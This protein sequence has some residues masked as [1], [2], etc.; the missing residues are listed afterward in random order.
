MPSLAVCA[1]F[2]DEA[3]FVE[4]WVAYHALIG[5]DHFFLYDNG[6]TDG[7]PEL[8]SNGPFRRQITLT[9]IPD[10]PGQFKAYRHFVDNFAKS[11][12]WAAFI[13]LDEFIQT[14]ETDD[15]HDLLPRY[16]G[17]SGVLLQ[18]LMFGPSGQEQRPDGL[19]IDSY[20]QRMPDDYLRN[21]HVKSLVRVA[22]ID[23]SRII[24]SAHLIPV[25]GTVCNSR[26]EEVAK[27]PIQPIACHDVVV[28]NHYYTKSR[29]DWETK[30][31]KGRADTHDEQLRRL[32]TWF[33]NYARDAVIYDTR[34]TRFSPAV[35]A[36]MA[37]E[38]AQR[39]LSQ[40]NEQHMES[41]FPLR[42]LGE[43]ALAPL[44]WT[45][46][47]RGEQSAWWGHVPFAHWLVGALQPQLLVELGTHNGVSY[48]AF[49]N[50][51]ARLDLATRCF[52]VD[53]WE[54]D[55]HAG[56]YGEAVY[57]GM[58]TFH[59]SRYGDFSTLMRCTFD[60]A[61]EHFADGSI[62]LL[63]IDGYH[64][65][66]AVRHDFETWRP[67][68]SDC[69][70]V[71]FHDI[72]VH[73][74]DF[75]VWRFWREVAATYPHFEFR[76]SSGLGVLAVGTDAPP[77][78][79]ALC[80]AADNP[81]LVTFRQ[82]IA[83]LGERWAAD[84]REAELRL[85]IEQ[86]RAE[87][88]ADVIERDNR[89]A[90]RDGRITERDNQ[91]VELEARL[92]Q[93]L[94]DAERAATA[95]LEGD[96]P[97]SSAPAESEIAR[98]KDQLDNATRELSAWRAHYEAVTCSTL[99]KAT[100]PIRR[101]AERVPTGMR[102]GM[103]GAVKFA[104]WSLRL[105][106]LSKLRERRLQLQASQ[107]ATEAAPAAPTAPAQTAVAASPP[108]AELAAGRRNDYAEWLMLYETV[109][110]RDRAAIK[111]AIAR[112]RNGPMIS[113]VLTG[114]DATEP[115]LRASIESIRGQLYSNWEL[116]IAVTVASPKAQYLLQEY[117][118]AEHR[119]KIG[120]DSVTGAPGNA[121]LRLVEGDYIALVEAGD[122]L[123][124]HALY[125]AVSSIATDPEVDLLF[126]DEDKID[127]AGVRYDPHFKSDWNPDL[128]LSCNVFGHLGVFRRSLVDQVGGFRD[129]YEGC[130]DYDL[131]L[132]CSALISA[133]R[134]RHLPY[135]LYH[136][137]TQRPETVFD[138]VGVTRRARLAIADHL[139]R[140][141]VTADVA[142][143]IAPFSHRVR[144]PV[145][146]PRPL[147]SLVIPTGGK[148]ELLRTCVTGILTRTGY[149]NLELVILHNSDTRREVFPYLEQLARDPR[150]TVVDSQSNFN[151]SRICNLGVSRAN[152]E[153]I[154]LLNDDLEVIGPDWLD[155]MVSHA[156]RPEIG[157]VGAMLYYPDQRIQHGGVVIGFGGVAGHAHLRR[158]R[159]DLSYFGRA[160]LTQNLSA[161]TAAC[162]VMRKSVYLEAGGLDETNLAVA[163]NDV[164]LCLRIR[165]RGY[166]IV[167][168][169]H[170]ELFHHESV[171]R[172]WDLAPE[173]ID[174]Y[175]AECAFMQQR[176]GETLQR[177]PYYNPN[178]SF[179]FPDFGLAFPP[180]IAKPWLVS[181]E[182]EAVSGEPMLVSAA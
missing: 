181:K 153:L 4:E 87:L 146:A 93:A 137:C 116:C 52:A 65:Y 119:I 32:L 54:G 72:E 108:P 8:L 46:E 17:F 151:F 98:L 162:A 62:D 71:L 35:R 58:R 89:V 159:G 150:V 103:R 59:D 95:P 129:G 121:A 11:Y 34:I 104:W 50:A 172:G 110:E 174:R 28:I 23:L 123:P 38:G 39:T 94:T 88:R 18:W 47:R 13:D 117:A 7:G 86:Q 112:L 177:D 154:G 118:A 114:T 113:V 85:R 126:S 157:M 29:E 12:D 80:A 96:A 97:R 175:K 75:G 70:V 133:Q 57:D 14:L 25:R 165:E 40:F 143:G 15:I 135:I 164:D 42:G 176:W 149:D 10:Q 125:V 140:R 170:A 90:E 107:T 36:A 78:I 63:H 84:M 30:V 66:D 81:R 43:P 20:T 22:D 105:Q 55:P 51:V 31:N 56:I 132:R 131:V 166:L 169:P 138:A 16:E 122:R 79:A 120:N 92:A 161:V 68:L 83:L 100:Y 156:L 124:E 69:A 145:P 60:E 134:I 91:I 180:R 136:R 19:V 74:D 152:G 115:Q 2:K 45:P 3:R 101:L 67:K 77:A 128:M 48:A 182:P 179:E 24:D 21:R 61:V 141:G 37:G 26:G 109:T 82:R 155:E 53:T 27:E 6:S 130:A 139:A 73:R 102:R 147:V 99:W 142:A 167:W 127:D 168:T 49:C 148:T 171:T 44:F 144:Y 158:N 9:P 5:V 163:Y 178:L 1:I 106:L 76:H 160:G 33:D 41:S 173:H 64:S 111:D